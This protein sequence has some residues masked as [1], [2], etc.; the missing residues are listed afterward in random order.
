MIRK[1][2]KALS[3]VAIGTATVFIAGKIIRATG[4]Y[5]GNRYYTKLGFD[6]HWIVYNS[7]FIDFIKSFKNELKYGLQR[8]TRGYDDPTFWSFYSHFDELVVKY[9]RWDIENGHG[10]PVIKDWTEENCH[11]KWTE[12]RKEMLH[13][14]EQS[15]E[16]Y[17]SEINE[18]DS[19]EQWDKYSER[20]KGIWQYQ[21]ENRKK[22][23]EM[24]Y[25]YYHHLWD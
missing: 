6:G 2:L 1:I 15:Q 9:L 10:S 13:Y 4:K 12:V 21:N 25:E 20:D 17:C 7:G 8:F 22:A 3:V 19:S 16:K 18:Y 24:F 23:F 11:E 14:F 5:K